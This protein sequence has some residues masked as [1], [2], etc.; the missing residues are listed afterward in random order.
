[1]LGFCEHALILLV[2]EHFCANNQELAARRL[3]SKPPTEYADLMRTK[4]KLANKVFFLIFQF[5]SD[6][7]RI[8]R[9]KYPLI[10]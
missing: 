2:V 1:V 8:C 10:L 6:S 5:C 3:I 7:P 4:K 9:F